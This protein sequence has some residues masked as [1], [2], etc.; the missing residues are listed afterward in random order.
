[1]KK[2]TKERKE[3][4][5]VLVLFGTVFVIL[6]ISV[7]LGMFIRNSAKP[8][9]ETEY[10]NGFVFTKSGKFWYTT[11]RNPVVQQDYNLDF[12]Y[13]PSQV[14]NV[15]VSGDPRKFFT[16]LQINNLTGAYFTFDPNDNL[17][18]MNVVGADLS[19]FLKVINGVTLVAGC[20]VNETV[21]CNRRPIVTCENQLD[22]AMVIYVKSSDVPK[23]SLDKNCLMIEGTGDDLLRAYTKLVFLWYNV[24]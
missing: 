10:S 8:K 4:H 17:T 11:I 19:K 5:S 16:L 7:A 1:M 2:E 24:L 20:T 9:I 13:P 14:R 15:S 23:I 22:K 21:A 12:R 3:D 18:Y 6:L